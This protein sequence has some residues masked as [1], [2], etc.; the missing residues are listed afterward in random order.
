[1][2]G[3]SLIL[4]LGDRVLT[5][6]VGGPGFNSQQHIQNTGFL[7]DLECLL[8]KIVIFQAFKYFESMD[9]KGWS[10]LMLVMKFD[11]QVATVE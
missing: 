3:R 8:L 11:S 4:W 5:W 2:S 9:V 6:L 10:G 1:M 7:I